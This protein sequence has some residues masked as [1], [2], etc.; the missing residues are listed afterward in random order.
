[1]TR[2]DPHGGLTAP[3]RRRSA[4]RGAG[5]PTPNPPCDGTCPILCENVRAGRPCSTRSRR[6][7]DYLGVRVVVEIGGA[8]H[9]DRRRLP[10]LLAEHQ[11]QC[12]ITPPA[13]FYELS[14]PATCQLRPALR[15]SQRPTGRLASVSAGERWWPGAGSNRRPSAFQ[16]RTPVQVSARRSWFVRPTCDIGCRSCAGASPHPRPPRAGSTP[17]R[18][19]G[20][21]PPPHAGSAADE[22]PSRRFRSASVAPVAAA[23]VCPV[24]RRSWNDSPGSPTFDRARTNA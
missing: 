7:D 22:C 17:A 12:P 6:S 21:G 20:P 16:A 5:S 4:Q 19:P 18:P 3:C 14:R 9:D 24:C 23:R 13:R 1:V 10:G 15:P 8:R 11:G 2:G